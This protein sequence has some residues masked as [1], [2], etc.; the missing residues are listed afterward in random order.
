MLLPAAACRSYFLLPTCIGYRA[1]EFR[2]APQSVL[3]RYTDGVT[4]AEDRDVDMPGED[5][6][7]ARLNAAASRT[8]ADLVDAVFAEVDEIA[9]SAPRRLK[10]AG[11]CSRCPA[12]RARFAQGVRRW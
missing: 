6:L 8:S 2:L 1:G 5:R 9:G 3:L 4:E 10:P 11:P 7:L 12:P